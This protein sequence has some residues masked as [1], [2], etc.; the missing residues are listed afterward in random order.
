MHCIL[1]EAGNTQQTNKIHSLAAYTALP[2]S[3][4]DHAYL[5]VRDHLMDITCIQQLYALNSNMFIGKK[6]QLAHPLHPESLFD[7]V[8][9]LESERVL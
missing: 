7:R 3:P 1:V 9:R 5:T 6:H 8:P 4:L 2:T